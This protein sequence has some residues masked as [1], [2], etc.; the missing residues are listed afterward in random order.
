MP[1]VPLPILSIGTGGI[2]ANAHYPAYLKA[3]L[4]VLGA[5]DRD[6]ERCS[7]VAQTVGAKP[8]ESLRELVASAPDE[9]IYDIALPGNAVLDTLAALPSGAYVLIQ[10]PLGENYQQAVTIAKLCHE[11]NLRAA[12]NFQL[13]WAPYM[14]GLASLINQGALGDCHEL[15]F[16]I[17]VHT[18]WENWPF[19]ES[20]PRMEMLYHSIHYIDL[21]RHL[22]GDPLSVKAHSIRDPRTPK[23][24][25]SRSTVIM[26]YGDFKR[27]VIQTYH[28]H[29]APKRHSESYM[30]I[31]GPKGC[32]WVQMGLNL[33]YP[34]G[35]EDKLEFWVEGKSEW[36]SVA[37]EGSWFPDAFVGPM[38]A[39]M[40][41]AR[42]GERPWTHVEDALKTMR[43]VDLAYQSSDLRAEKF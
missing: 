13:R 12:V 16:K 7:R 15:E 27:A 10:K 36:E 33:N 25:S 34:H 8:Y 20:A 39:M 28:G 22:W 26:D 11:K 41:W 24:E 4:S 9:C 19:L 5:Y 37:L 32:A 6:L 17:N 2:V 42:G 3:S 29:V 30:R 23:L 43:C 35:A 40:I 38:A 14:L 31:E 21:V 1:S 18:P